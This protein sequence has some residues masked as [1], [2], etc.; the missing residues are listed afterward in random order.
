MG[1][2]AML[3]LIANFCVVAF[4]AELLNHERYRTRRTAESILRTLD[5]LGALVVRRFVDLLLFRYVFSSKSSPLDSG[6]VNVAVN[7]LLVLLF[8]RCDGYFADNAVQRVAEGMRSLV[9][10]FA[11]VV[12]TAW[13]ELMGLATDSIAGIDVEEI[14]FSKSLAK[15]LLTLSILVIVGPAWAKHILPKVSNSE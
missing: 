6:M 5:W 7:T 10:P 12:G 2:A 3:V 13:D 15:F 4:G 9:K 11:L 8:I 1:M 14:A